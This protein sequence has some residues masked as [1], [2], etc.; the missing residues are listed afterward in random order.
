M[1][2]VPGHTGYMGEPDFQRSTTGNAEPGGKPQ[3]TVQSVARAAQLLKALA[4]FS[5]PTSLSD[6]ARRVD[7]SKPA[8]YNLLKTL[9][10]D[11]LV[12]KDA[13]A[14]YQLSWGM[15]EL[16]SAVMRS[17][18]LTRLSRFH[19]D[20]LAAGTN[21]AV[22]LGILD[23][24]NVLYLDR[25]QSSAT[26]GMVANTG[27]RSSLHATA[28]GKVLLAN[29]DEA[30]KREYIDRGLKAYTSN[31][32]TDEAALL[33]ELAKTERRGYATCWE[34]REVGLA[35]LAVAL[36][37]HAGTVQAALTV[38]APSSRLN[39]RH[40]SEFLVPLQ[41]EAEAISAKLGW[42]PPS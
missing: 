6:L 22:L 23:N 29:Q 26:F 33:D 1:S 27:R 32:I 20:R 28:S 4:R 34:E 42:T 9:E 10:V 12:S 31:T 37:N 24:D 16:G 40:I 18:E 35:S 21:T 39:Q 36:R 7:L 8:T 2:R 41:R 17:V 19:L 14:R 38:A 11:G 13:E 15:Y 25:G 30:Y 3:R 5:R